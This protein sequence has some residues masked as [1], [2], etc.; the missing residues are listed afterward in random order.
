MTT[1]HDQNKAE[2][3]V[4]GFVV[5][6]I[7]GSTAIA[8]WAINSRADKPA[9]NQTTQESGQNDTSSEPD[10]SVLTSINSQGVLDFLTEEKSGFLYVGRP[11]CPVCQVF[12]PILTEVVKENNLTVFYFNTDETRSESAWND[13]LD[14]VDVPGVPTF[15]YIRDGQIVARFNNNGIESEDAILEFIRSNS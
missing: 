1:K 12:A 5:L 8:V 15:M 4:L 10:F 13:A 7:I 14:A 2:K 11:S 9:E 3:L 6:L